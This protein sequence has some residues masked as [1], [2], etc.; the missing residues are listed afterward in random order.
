MYFEEETNT[1]ILVFKNPEKTWFKWISKNLLRRWNKETKGPQ[2]IYLSWAPSEYAWERRFSSLEEIIT[3]L[4]ESFSI[5][6]VYGIGSYFDNDIP[7]TWTKNDIDLI[8]IVVNLDGVP[9]NE[10]NNSR[11]I[12]KRIDDVEVFIGFNTITGLNDKVQFHKESFANYGWA[13]HE[14]KLP[15]NFKLLSGEDIRDKLPNLTEI[16]HDFEDILPRILYH[17][18]KSFEAENNSNKVEASKRFTKAVFKFTYYLCVIDNNDFLPTSTIL[19]AKRVKELCSQGRLCQ[20]MDRFIENCVIYRTYK[21]F[22][23]DIKILRED[24]IIYIFTLAR[25]GVLHRNFSTNDLSHLL[26]ITYD[27]FPNLIKILKKFFF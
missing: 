19:S 3:F 13:L 22:R 12:I 5:I 25:E 2:D 15:E 10:S 4:N 23:E 6:I 24:F 17:L 26:E 1:H 16:Q 9:F 18:E 27:G 21:E 11:S 20:I 8:A 7:P 14:L